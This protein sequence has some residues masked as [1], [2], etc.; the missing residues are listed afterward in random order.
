[1]TYDGAVEIRFFPAFG[2]YLVSALVLEED[3]QGSVTALS[4]TYVKMGKRKLAL[5]CVTSGQTN[6]ISLQHSSQLFGSTSTIE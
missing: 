6:R 2:F 3:S 1:M 5:R 4:D